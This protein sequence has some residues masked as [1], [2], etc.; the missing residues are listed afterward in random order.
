MNSLYNNIILTHWPSGKW[1]RSKGTFGYMFEDKKKYK[2]SF[3]NIFY[4]VTLSTKNSIVFLCKKL[5][6][7]NMLLEELLAD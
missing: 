5:V 1:A 7:T 3:V 6:N 4:K 2:L